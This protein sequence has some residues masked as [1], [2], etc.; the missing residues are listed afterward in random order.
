VLGVVVGDEDGEEALA[1]LVTLALAA[2]SAL[3][4]S[5]EAPE[6]LTPSKR[7]RSCWSRKF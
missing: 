7:T 4:R 6:G 2:S 1:D 5:L 3:A